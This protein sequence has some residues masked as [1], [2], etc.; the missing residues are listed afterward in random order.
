[1]LNDDYIF[2]HLYTI[3]SL[4]NVVLFIKVQLAITRP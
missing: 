4:Y 3:K 2:S 1:M